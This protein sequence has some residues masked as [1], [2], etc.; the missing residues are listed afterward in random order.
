[1][2]NSF[3]ISVISNS[4]LTDFKNIKKSTLFT[5]DNEGHNLIFLLSPFRVK[6]EKEEKSN[7]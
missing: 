7:K 2:R 3:E 6:G 5:A 4:T 1:L